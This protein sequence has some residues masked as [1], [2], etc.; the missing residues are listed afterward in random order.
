MKY[1]T[2]GQIIHPRHGSFV[3]DEKLMAIQQTRLTYTRPGTRKG[4]WIKDQFG[5]D[6][7]SCCDNRLAISR[8]RPSNYSGMVQLKRRFCSMVDAR[9]E[10]LGTLVGW[11]GMGWHLRG[12]HSRHDGLPRIL[13]S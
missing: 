11:D 5:W 3:A 8:T 6:M 12:A 7:P 10:D 13:I 4:G 2:S 9:H 1:T